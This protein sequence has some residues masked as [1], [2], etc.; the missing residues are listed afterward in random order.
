MGIDQPLLGGLLIPVKSC[1][2]ILCHT[3][4]VAEHQTQIVLGTD[5]PLLGGLLIPVK[6]RFFVQCYT[7]T[8]VEHA[9]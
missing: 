9:A 3:I 4:T 2:F 8:L 5:Q 7:I 1:F 6:S